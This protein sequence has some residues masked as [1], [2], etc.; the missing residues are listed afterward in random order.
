MKYWSIVKSGLIRKRARTTLTILSIAVAFTLFA[1]G[2]S[3]AVAFTS[4]VD[5]AG[6]DRLIVSSQLSFTQALPL[7]MKQRILALD[8]VDKV[9]YRQWFGGTYIDPKNYF[10]KWPVPN[11]FFDVY[12]EFK[13][14]EEAKE[15]FSRN[16]MGMI[17][18]KD[19]ADKYGWK[20]GDRI[21]IIADIWPKSDG[22]VWE[23]DLV[24]TYEG[25]EGGEVYFNWKY[26]DEA[27]AYENGQ[28]GQF[29]V[30][31]KDA[32]QAESVAKSIDLLFANSSN[33]TKTSTE[34]AFARAFS[35]QVGDIGFIINSVLAASFFTILLLT[36]NTMSQA[37]RER[38]SEL[39]VLKSIGFS[40]LTVMSFIL[41]ESVILCFLGALL[42][43]LV[44]AS[45][46]PF[47]AKI[48][49]SFAGEI[50][51]GYSIITS[52]FLVAFLTAAVSGVVPAFSALR[53]N[54]VDALRKN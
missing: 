40:D 22:S 27:R 28:V 14:P 16:I 33:E 2:R 39:G 46:F 43:L 17:A 42:G 47:F 51:F 34:A 19:I 48:S 54:V 31:V 13:V 52:A 32:S 30:K 11:D 49:I 18:A 50:K 1:L 38:T 21:P 36:G 53:L 6:E 8:G 29:A 10:P 3:V 9:V 4:E 23:F 41:Y 15:A 24:G 20:V 44:A 5:F 7:G 45:L 26:F 25:G 35:E 12:P 37:V